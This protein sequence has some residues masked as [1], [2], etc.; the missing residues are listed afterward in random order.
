M[1]HHVLLLREEMDG[2]RPLF[3]TLRDGDPVAP[4]STEKY[5]VLRSPIPL[6]G[7]FCLVTP[8]D[9]RFCSVG[10]EH[11]HLE[12]EWADPDPDELG[13]ARQEAARG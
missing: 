2:E 3:V 10:A 12:G 6:G 9:E 4:P 8:S 5:R 11:E 1:F 13:V 7:F